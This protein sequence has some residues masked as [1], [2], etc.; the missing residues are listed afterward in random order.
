MRCET[1]GR[2]KSGPGESFNGMQGKTSGVPT[3]GALPR[4]LTVPE[5]EAIV[6]DSGTLVEVQQ[7]ARVSRELA[8]RIVRSLGLEDELRSNGRWDWR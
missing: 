4:H 1:E 6:R 2:F 8:R 3:D 5:F 7:R